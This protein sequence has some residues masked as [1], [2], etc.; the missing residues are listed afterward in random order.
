MHSM[1]LMSPVSVVY[2][3]V[4]SLAESRTQT[5]S[6]KSHLL[7]AHNVFIPSIQSC[8]GISLYLWI[9][10]GK[11]IFGSLQSAET[12]SLNRLFKYSFV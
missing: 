4:I 11:V 9:L 2:K 1:E 10:T 5:F 6:E 7:K 8:S 12:V 3:M